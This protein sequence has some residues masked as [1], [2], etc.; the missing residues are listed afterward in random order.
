MPNLKDILS[1]NISSVKW[2]LVIE[3]E[4]TFRSIAASPFWTTL[5]T[6]GIMITAKGYP[7]ISTRAMLRFLS[8]PSPQNGFCAPPVYA[9]VDF[10]PDGIAILSTYKYGSKNLAHETSHMCLPQIHW[11]GLH[12]E[13]VLS[14]EATHAD[15]GLLTLTARDRKKVRSMLEWQVLEGDQGLRRDLQVMLMLN[16]KAE[17]QLL[18]ATSDGMSNL[19]EENLPV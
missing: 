6:S 16:F 2:I 13:H 12:S 14:G 18:D 1:A 10:D 19:L 17:L 8:S 15:Q 5:S 9:M 7:D 4:A 3:K 11:L